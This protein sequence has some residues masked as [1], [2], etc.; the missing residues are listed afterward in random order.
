MEFNLP[1]NKEQMYSILEE[2]FYHYRIKR[3]GYEELQL[4]PLVLERLEYRHPEE[5]EIL[6]MAE[7]ALRGEQEREL[8]SKKAEY[9]LMISSLENKINL[10]T[11]SKEEQIANIN[12]LYESSIEKVEKQAEKNGLISSGIAVDKVAQLEAEK[13][14]KIAEVVEKKNSEIEGYTAEIDVKRKELENL[15]EV[16]A[17][18]HVMDVDKKFVEMRANYQAIEREVFKYNNSLDEKE[19]RYQNTIMQTNASLKLKFMEISSGEFTK[20]QLVEMGYYADVI[21]CIRGYFDVLDAEIAYQEFCSDQKIMIY[22]DDYYSN[23][24]YLYRARAGL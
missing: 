12:K 8:M 3:P 2:L 19:Q 22:L 4:E 7:I 15:T 21:R 5:S 13:N 17:D 9:E 20:D 14:A 1:T 24:L 6:E 10:C 11:L 16:Y 18:V 23:V